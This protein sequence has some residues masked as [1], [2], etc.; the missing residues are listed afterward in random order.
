MR[1]L[2]FFNLVSIEFHKVSVTCGIPDRDN[3]A[4]NKY[5]LE[6]IFKVSIVNYHYV[7]SITEM[8]AYLANVT[9]VM[10]Q[11]NKSFLLSNCH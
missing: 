8:N 10:K 6:K 1:I 7:G 9:H 3:P 5:L 11:M 4:R 2:A